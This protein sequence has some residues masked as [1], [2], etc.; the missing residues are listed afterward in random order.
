MNVRSG[1][2]LPAA[3]ATLVVVAAMLAPGAI[4]LAPAT[5]AHAPL[6]LGTFGA[7]TFC[8]D[9]SDDNQPIGPGQRFE[10]GIGAVYALFEYH[11]MKPGQSWSR[12]WELNGH[13]FAERKGLS[14]NRGADGWLSP[15]IALEGGLS[16]GEY[17]LSLFVDGSLAQSATF[18]V[19][20]DDQPQGP[21][22]FGPITFSQEI[23]DSRDPVFP[24][25]EFS[26]GTPRV[27]AVFI[28][29]N[30]RRGQSWSK[31]WLLNGEVFE[32]A[33]FTWDGDRDGVT[34]LSVASDADSLRPGNYVLNLFVDGRLSRSASFVVRD[35]ESR[36]PAR[37]EE[38]VDAELLTA[39]YKLRSCPSQSIQDMADLALDHHIPI[40]IGRISMDAL[41]AYSYECAEPPRAGEILVTRQH[42]NE[43]TWEELTA[44]LAHELT[45]ALQHLSD[46]YP[47]NCT[48]DK[49]FL[50]FR[51]QLSVLRDFG[52]EDL[53]EPYSGLWQSDGSL[54]EA[55]LWGVIQ[56]LYP[57]CPEY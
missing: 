54:D 19:V 39:W 6:L 10:A 15:S 14:W 33:T 13:V 23:R 49:E 47:C 56:E 11:N 27:Y 57:E 7:I 48:I 3:I 51:T 32:G 41:A 43:S 2:S 46:Q 22:S 36:E 1:M 44:T 50:A 21:A 52:R 45:H 8:K 16:E 17:T 24:S 29:T 34:Y 37:P 28:Y 35:V 30:M 5:P 53:L 9:V 25:W 55:K 38:V 18:E 40:R 12:V 4:A 20:R 42:W 26:F 31:Q